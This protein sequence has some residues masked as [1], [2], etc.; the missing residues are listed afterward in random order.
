MLLRALNRVL[1]PGFLLLIGF[2]FCD[3]VLAAQLHDN[4]LIVKYRDEQA[5]SSP[6]KLELVRAASADQVS[7]LKKRLAADPDVEY[8]EINQTA[9]ALFSPN[10]P[11]FVSRSQWN[12][13]QVNAPAAWNI[14]PGAGNGVIVAVLDTGVAYE[15]N[16]IYR[17]VPD[18]LPETFVPGWDFV[19]D[20][21]SPNDD[22]G[23]GTVVAGVIAQ[24]TNN[25]Y[26][27]AG[28][29]YGA[30]I[31]PVKVLDQYGIGNSYDIARGIRWAADNGA[32]VINLSLGVDKPSRAIK[33]AVDYARKIKKVIVVAAAGNGGNR[34]EYPR[35]KGGLM[36]PARYSSVIS[37]GAT[38]YGKK[39]ANY[40]QYGR[41]LD[42]MAPGGEIN[43]LDKN[44]DG[45][46]DG[47]VQQTIRQANWR[48]GTVADPSRYG[49]SWF[50]GTSLASPHVAA[51]AAIIIG[52]GVTKPVRVCRA[53][54]KSAKDLG[55]RGFDKKH[56]HGLLNV[57]AALRYSTSR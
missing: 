4:E 27:A 29:A 54:T 22:H 46:P 19:N 55:R 24:A 9:R 47:I 52:H 35:Y 49:F 6:P 33:N 44:H 2:I 28:L 45:Y 37:V 14:A 11:L 12:L 36:Y 10:D 21:N 41:R 25:S 13:K 42:L 50:E 34:R 23:H 15:D 16:G 1:L 8:V 20:D 53:L 5:T 51:A 43:R 40:S 31:M 32:K 7:V 38:R 56:G 3:T 30:R 39:R 17:R 18:L 48:A 57:A 26:G